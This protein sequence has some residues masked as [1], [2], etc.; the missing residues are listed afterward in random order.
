MS[1][2]PISVRNIMTEARVRPPRCPHCTSVFA[3][4]W[5]KLG[6]VDA[7]SFQSH[8]LLFFRKKVFKSLDFFFSLSKSFHF[9][10]PIEHTEEIRG[11]LFE[12]SILGKWC[13][14]CWVSHNEWCPWCRL[15][16]PKFDMGTF[17]Q[18]GCLFLIQNR[19]SH[20]YSMGS[21]KYSRYMSFIF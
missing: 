8:F 7:V 4:F 14:G 11:I 1:S 5:V 10:H 15:P 12:V 9:Y 2:F 13:S 17:F 20:A 6:F 18:L 3:V 21:I 16:V 19:F